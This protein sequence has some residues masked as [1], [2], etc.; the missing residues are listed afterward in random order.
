MPD[1]ETQLALAD[2]APAA[3]E[4]ASACG[5]TLVRDPDDPL[6]YWLTL[7][8]RAAVSETFYARI[9]WT[10]YP[11]SPPSVKFADTLGGRLDAASAWPLIPGYRPAAFDICQ[12]F[13]AEGFSVH[14][15]WLS[16]PEAWSATGNPF[17]WVVS[18]LVH[19][20]ADRYQGRAA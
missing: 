19:D 14:P 4:H 2:D 8:P 20:I 18:I 3:L 1:V 5:A 6:V 7:S 10:R 13:T 11:H 12:P 17:L 9:A 16:G 15:D